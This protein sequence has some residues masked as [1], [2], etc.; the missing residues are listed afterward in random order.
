[1]QLVL[2]GLT[3]LPLLLLGCTTE[4]YKFDQSPEQ[5]GTDTVRQNDTVR[6]DSETVALDA[7]GTDEV[8]CN[9]EDPDDDC[10]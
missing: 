4:P 5:A 7:G 1:M 10:Q 9:P 6:V 2:V 3:V 8:M